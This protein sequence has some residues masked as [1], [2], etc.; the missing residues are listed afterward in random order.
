MPGLTGSLGT[1]VTVHEGVGVEG[2]SQEKKV[3][4]DVWI[5][6]LKVPSWR[7]SEKAPCGSG[8]QGGL[9]CFSRK[10]PGTC[11]LPSWCRDPGAP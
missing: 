8:P 9:A 3:T 11:T 4:M 1:P 7:G 10:E 2:R 6:K 5:R